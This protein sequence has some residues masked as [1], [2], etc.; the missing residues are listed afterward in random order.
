MQTE[1]PA[2]LQV[3]PRK[4]DIHSG[5]GG[6]VTLGDLSPVSKRLKRETDRLPLPCAEAKNE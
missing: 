4:Q 1:N 3:V 5:S 2:N 6:P